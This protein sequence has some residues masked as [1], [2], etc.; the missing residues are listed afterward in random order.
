MSEIR[1]ILNDLLSRKI[2]IDTAEQL[3]KT[4]DVNQDVKIDVARLK[5]LRIKNNYT[6]R[7][8]E[9]MTGISNAYLSQLETGRIKNPSHRNILILNALYA[10]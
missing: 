5:E 4:V 3:I 9:G 1:I 10:K 7:A 6:L 8:V 2:T